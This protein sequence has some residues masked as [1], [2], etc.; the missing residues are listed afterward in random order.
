MSDKCPQNFLQ[1]VGQ[2]SVSDKCPVTLLN[3][4]FKSSVTGPSNCYLENIKIRVNPPQVIF[5][6]PKCNIGTYLCY[7]IRKYNTASLQTSE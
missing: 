6:K 5:I 1:V 4:T 7:S 2:M 3:D